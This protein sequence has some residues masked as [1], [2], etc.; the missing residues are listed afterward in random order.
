MTSRGFRTVANESRTPLLPARHATQLQVAA[1]LL[2]LPALAVIGSLVLLIA[3]RNRAESTVANLATLIPLGWAFAAGMVASVN[4][5]GFFMLPAYV[6][7]QLGARGA[8]GSSRARR[9]SRALGLAVVATSGFLLI[10]GV[11]GLVIASGG[12]WLIRTFPYAG[13]TIGAALTLL[14]VWMLRSGRTIGLLAASRTYVVPHRSLRNIFL[15]GI[16]YAAGSLSCTL[17]VFLLVV[18]TSL[19]SE[20]LLA[21]FSQF[22][23][24]GLG[25]GTVLMLVTIGTALF[26]D[27]LTGL[28]RAIVPHVHRLSAL[29]LIGAGLYLVY[30]WVWFSGSIL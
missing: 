9:V 8:L 16:A 18:G 30:Y 4:P 26:Q 27:M 6:S 15:F 19:A 1:M 3:V 14:G 28:V 12:Q 29:F 24:F 7:Y 20:R 2:L 17:P 10:L 13:V 5:C 11:V 22:I 25:M 21:S 23:S